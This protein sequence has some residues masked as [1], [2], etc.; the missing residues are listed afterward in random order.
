VLNIVENANG[1]VTA[2]EEA[3]GVSNLHVSPARDGK[4]YLVS[5]GQ[6]QVYD[7]AA[8]TFTPLGVGVNL[9]PTEIGWVRL[10]DQTAFP[11]ETL[12]VVGHYLGQTYL[13]KYNPSNG[14]TRNA[15]VAGAP[16]QPTDIHSV[17]AGP[18]GKI[19]TGGYL[20]GGTGVYR[21]LHGDANDAAPELVHRGMSQTD[22]ILSYQDRVYFGTYSG[23]RIYE[24]DPAS[25]WGTDNP[26]LMAALSTQGQDRPFTMAA[27]DGK[28][29]VGTV[30]KYGAYD[31]AMT[32]FDLATGQ[33]TVKRN[34][35]ADQGVVALAYHGGKV[36]GG[37]TIRA[38]L[39]ADTDPRADQAR[40]FAYDLATGTTTER[41]L[42]LPGGRKPTAIT[43]LST[44]DGKIW[45]LAEG[46]LFVF[47]PAT[48]SFSTAPVQKF[49]AVDYRPNGT[50]RDAAMT[51]T[52]KDTAS[53]YVT[54][55]GALYRIAK[56][57]LAVTQLAGGAYGITVDQLGDIYYYN[58][59][60]LF[61]Y[62]P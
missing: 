40:F 21:P 10:A 12:I 39:G 32:I 35:V 29:F 62:L 61:R 6:L 36:Y 30:P 16:V 1:T 51:T 59:V 18:D 28:L 19:Y 31:G 33:V 50:W 48:N 14:A 7:I 25:P 47:N 24:Y 20:T 11:G 42:T 2:T 8:R 60:N 55:G 5:R 23:A 58:D 26:R 38:G 9:T 54:I 52:P 13:F 44:V 15:L 46:F 22:S 4:V 17:G 49:S 57:T 43:A 3:S 41:T 37:T 56:S 27:G 53:V 45:G 34:L